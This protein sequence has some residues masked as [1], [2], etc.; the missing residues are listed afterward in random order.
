LTKAQG[1]QGKGAESSTTQEGQ[2]EENKTKL[3]SS[4]FA[5]LGKAELRQ[6][7]SDPFWIKV[8]WTL[9]ILFWILWLGLLAGA[10][11][12]LTISPKKCSKTK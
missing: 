6:S 9:F 10:V 1:D 5:G 7:I 3:T 12:I 2:D 11:L 4:E 8:R